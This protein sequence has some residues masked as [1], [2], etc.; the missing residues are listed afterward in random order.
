MYLLLQQLPH[1]PKHTIAHL[2]T[3][4]VI[5]LLGPVNVNHQEG[6]GMVVPLKILTL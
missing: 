6:D 4:S 1:F 5:N 3:K 2:M